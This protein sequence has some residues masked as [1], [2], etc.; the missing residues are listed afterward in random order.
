VTITNDFKGSCLIVKDNGS[1][2]ECYTSTGLGL[3]NMTMRAVNLKG[4]LEFD[5]E[6][7][8]EVKLFLPFTL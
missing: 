5:K 1:K 4:K 3:S 2:K 6:S 7:G 8:F